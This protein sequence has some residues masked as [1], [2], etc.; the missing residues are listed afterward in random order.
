MHAGPVSQQSIAPM[1]TQT[2]PEPMSRLLDHPAVGAGLR[3]DLRAASRGAAHPGPTPPDELFMGRYLLLHELGRGGM[4]TVHLAYQTDIARYVAL[5]RI[6]E[7]N[8]GLASAEG[9]FRREYR[10]LAAVHHP[11]VP[12]IHDCGRSDDLIS[13]FTMEIIDGPSLRA[14]LAG[15]RFEPVESINIAIELARILAAAHAAGVIHR[16]VKP[17]NVV[18]EASGRVRLIDFGICVFLPKYKAR[19]IR[20]HSE[21]EY[22]TGSMEIAGTIGYTDPALFEGH[23]VQVQSD[24]FSVAVILYEML[25]GRRLH[26]ERAG[27]FQTIDSGEFAPEL[28]PVVAEIRRGAERLPKDRHAS[29]DEFIRGLEIARSVFLRTKISRPRG[30][31]LALSLASLAVLAMLGVFWGSG[32]SIG[33]VG[34]YAKVEPAAEVSPGLA[35]VTQARPA[36]VSPAAG[37]VE[38]A[39][40]VTPARPAEVVPVARVA[41]VEPAFNRGPAPR[42]RAKAQATPASRSIADPVKAV[43]AAAAACLTTQDPVNLEVMVTAER[44]VLKRVEW[45]PYNPEDATE[46]C[47]ARAI[48]SVKFPETYP[49]GSFRLKVRGR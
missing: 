12:T 14:S 6:L 15:R 24:I 40:A 32:R 4:G 21:D 35:E 13:Y 5:K 26:D 8:V 34:G 10:A 36:E 11:G 27:R 42:T 45:A 44:A 23:P 33:M 43:G 39:A 47:F 46:S 2:P 16:D 18:L 1:D 20:P 9:W 31:D 29:M 25:A 17:A 22:Q 3:S 37:T 28:A 49:A 38:P 41:E 48:G 19:V 30:R 7:R